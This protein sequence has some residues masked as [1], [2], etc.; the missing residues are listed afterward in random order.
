[1]K[2]H[3]FVAVDT[4]LPNGGTLIHDRRS[5]Q[6]DRL[7]TVC[8]VLKRVRRSFPQAYAVKSTFIR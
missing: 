7:S 8:R 4:K 5:R 3:Y 1:M 2:T 6:I